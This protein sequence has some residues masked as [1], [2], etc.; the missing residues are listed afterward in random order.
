MVNSLWKRLLNC[1]RTD[2]GQSGQCHCAVVT[3]VSVATCPNL[4]L[5]VIWYMTLWLW[6]MGCWTFKRNVQPMYSWRPYGLLDNEDEDTRIMSKRIQI[7]TVLHSFSTQNNCFSE[8][9]LWETAN[10]AHW[11]ITKLSAPSLNTGTDLQNVILWKSYPEIQT[12][13]S[14]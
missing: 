7:F 9:S 2:W 6:T 11:N 3:A 13:S 14:E 12:S 8:M 4:A 10:L 5:Q 1:R